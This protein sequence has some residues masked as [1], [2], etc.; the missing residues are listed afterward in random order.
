MFQVVCSVAGLCNSA[1]NDELL[2]KMHSVN[3]QLEDDDAPN[4][5]KCSGCGLVVSQIKENFNSKSRDQVLESLLKVNFV[6]DC[7]LF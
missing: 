2:S 6:L 7:L 4:S 5:Q 3:R 1:S